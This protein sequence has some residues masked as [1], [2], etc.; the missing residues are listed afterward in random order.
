MQTGVDLPPLA[1]V[2]QH[3]CRVALDLRRTQSV[4]KQGIAPGAAR[5]Y[6]PADGSS[7]VTYRFAASHASKNRGRSTSVRERVRSP[8][9]S[10][11]RRWLTY[12]LGSC[13]MG[14]TDG[15]GGHNNRQTGRQR[16]RQTDTR[17]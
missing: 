5:R 9:I 15:G 16:D 6:A 14:Q 2:E 10:G 7:T 3:Q 1:V 12:S 17:P 13:A 11:G 4:H 8:H